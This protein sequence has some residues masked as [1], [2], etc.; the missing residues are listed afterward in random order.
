LCQY[1]SHLAMT[2]P[3][4]YFSLAQFSGTDENTQ[5]YLIWEPVGSIAFVEVVHDNHWG[6]VYSS[7]YLVGDF[8]VFVACVT[9]L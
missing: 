3:K 8:C 7:E 5:G 1:N 9:Y 4:R 2:F 6:N